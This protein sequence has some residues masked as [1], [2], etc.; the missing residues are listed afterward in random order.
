MTNHKGPG[1][2]HHVIQRGTD[3]QQLFFTDDDYRSFIGILAEACTECNVMVWGYCLMPDHVHLIAIPKRESAID[4]ALGTAIRRYT[5]SLKS[6]NAP[7]IPL[8]RKKA[9]RHLLDETYLIKCARYVEINAVKRDY[10]TSAEEW[11]WSSTKAHING[12]DDILVTVAPLLDR[13]RQNWSDFLDTPI[14]SQEADLFYAHELSGEP[15]AKVG[16]P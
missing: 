2:P 11:P 7:V 10:V 8:F 16:A 1:L 3:G 14:P 6:K 4:D 5:E 9:A 13:I 15:M 12:Q